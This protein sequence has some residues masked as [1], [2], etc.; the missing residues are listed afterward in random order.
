MNT[1]S[2]LF[3]Q[4]QHIAESRWGSSHANG[5]LLLFRLAFVCV[6]FERHLPVQRGIGGLIH[7]AL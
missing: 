6:G 4:D 2:R 3:C 7:L 5:L 1:A